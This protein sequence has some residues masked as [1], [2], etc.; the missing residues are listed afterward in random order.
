[1]APEQ[2]INP[3]RQRAAGRRVRPRR[4]AGLRGHRPQPVRHRPAGVDAVPDREPRTRPGRGAAGHRGHRAGLPGQGPRPAAGRRP[5]WPPGCATTGAAVPARRPGS[6]SCRSPARRTPTRPRPPAAGARPGR[7][8]RWRGRRRAGRGWSLIGRCW[9]CSG[10]RTDHPRRGAAARDR[11]GHP[12]RRREQLAGARPRTARRRATSTGCA[13][14]GT[15]WPPSALGHHPAADRRPGGGPARLPG[16]PRPQHRH[17]G[18]RAGRLHRAARRGPDRGDPHPVRPDRRRVHRG[19]AV[20]HPGQGRRWRP[21]TRSPSTAYKTGIDRFADG[22]RNLS[23][24]A[25]L[26]Q[27]HHAAARL[28]RG[29]RVGAPVHRLSE[30][31]IGP[32]SRRAAQRGRQLARRSS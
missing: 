32:I 20:V 8:G 28:H 15:C 18:R 11:G 1:M 13:R 24:A 22:V 27:G 29:V 5:R 7:P 2:V 10:P 12:G 23:L 25:Q 9:S 3:D 16:H 31:T 21:A 4:D 19:Q 17:R 6:P 26:M 14:P 30:R